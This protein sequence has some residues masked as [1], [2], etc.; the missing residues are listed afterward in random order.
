LTQKGKEMTA[1]LA[2]EDGSKKKLPIACVI[3]IILD[4]KGQVLLHHRLKEPFYDYYG[5]P[6]GKME[7][8]ETILGTAARELKEET[9][10]QAQFSLNAIYNINT[11]NNNIIAYHYIHFVMKGI[12]PEGTLTPKNR[13]GTFEWIPITELK[14]YKLFPD[15]LH[16][17]QGVLQDTFR[18]IEM[19][20]SMQ[21]GEFT[22]SYI[23][24][25]LFPEQDPKKHNS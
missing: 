15:N 24:S 19:E 23:K 9:G 1:F 17:M 25:E 3:L 2:G 12:I 6:S 20:R 16:K 22:G 4:G 8:G 7:Y 11:F 14:N 10:L 13:E 5:F 18:V 21:D